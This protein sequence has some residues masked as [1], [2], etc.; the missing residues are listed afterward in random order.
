MKCPECGK[1]L[2]PSTFRSM[3]SS[4]AATKSAIEIVRV[5]DARR[6]VDAMFPEG[7]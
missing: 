4:V 7:D 5:L 2:V 1:D 3:P 6:D